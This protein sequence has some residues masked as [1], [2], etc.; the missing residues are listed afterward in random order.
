MKKLFIVLLIPL[1]MATQCDDDKILNYQTS[2]F[3]ENNSS[4]DLILVTE[5]NTEIV[6]ESQTN[7]QIGNDI[8]DSNIAVMPSEN[9]LFNSLELYKL[10]PNDN[11]ILAYQQEI[12]NDDL[13][14]FDDSGI[15]LYQYTLVLTDDL[16]D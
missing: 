13:W 7:Y 12:I 11:L 14:L 1:L 8:R 9:N 3:I 15:S 2:Y 10:D 6:I 4:I 16:I 5:D